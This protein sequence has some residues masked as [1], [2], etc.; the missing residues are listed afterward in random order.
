MLCKVTRENCVVKRV[1]L[2]GIHKLH[3]AKEEEILTIF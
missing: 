3:V 1:I 2:Y